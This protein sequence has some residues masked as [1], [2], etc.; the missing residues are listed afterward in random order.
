MKHIIHLD[1]DAFY[2]S[3]EVMDNPKLRGRPVIVGGERERGVVS[4]AS[5]EARTFGVH[6]AQPIATAMRL[7]PK[8][9]FLPVRMERYKE[10]SH[11]IFGIFRLFTPLVEP[12]SI[13]EAFLDVTGSGRLFG[14]PEEIATKIKRLV[15]ERTGLTV[16]AGV[17]PTKLVAKIAS[18]MEKP[19]GL[20]V[21]S[22]EAVHAFLEPLPIGKLWGVGEVTRKKLLRLGVRTIGDLKR[23]PLDLLTRKFGK[24]GAHLHFS[25][26]GIDERR[27]ELTHQV[28]SIGREETYLQD[29]RDLATA[30]REILSLATRVARRMRRAGFAGKTVTLKVKYH[31]FVQVT[32]SVTLSEP[33]DDEREIY[34]S[35]CRLLKTT[36]VGRRAVRLLGISLSH[37]ATPESARQLALFREAEL[38]Q[39]RQD[40]NTTVDAICER[41]GETAIRPGTLLR[42]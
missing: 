14:S 40:L 34:R 30:N 36:E 8:G 19:D 6:S 26:S 35:C 7:C 27:V 31:D 17:A 37:L 3:V 1:M 10:V 25:S 32:R 13:D 28:K 41:F 15:Y 9:V 12:L 39:K 11:E 21:V 20:T 23:L 16:S 42:K 38:N 18:D 33:T 5:Y 24:H 2:A 22:T 29:I 4:A